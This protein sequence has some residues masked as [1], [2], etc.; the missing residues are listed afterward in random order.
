VFTILLNIYEMRCLYGHPY[1]EAPTDE[2]VTHAAAMVVEHVLAQP[3]RLRHGFGKPLLKSL[4]EEK[5]FL[6]D[7][8]SAVE[9]FAAET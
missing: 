4:L 2:Q 3:V 1:E 9:A 5:N 8:A 7:Q 6:D